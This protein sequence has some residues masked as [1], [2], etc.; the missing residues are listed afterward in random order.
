MDLKTQRNNEVLK[1]HNEGQ[2]VRQIADHFG[3]SK[4]AVHKIISAVIV[5]ENEPLKELIKPVLT[6]NEVRIASFVG[7]QRVAPNEYVNKDT[8]ELIKVAFIK[9]TKPNQYGYFVKV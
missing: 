1:A 7:F 6:G 3:I 5:K 2:T 8:S 9:A 4:S